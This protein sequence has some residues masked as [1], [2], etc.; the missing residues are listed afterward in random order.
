[1]AEAVDNANSSADIAVELSPLQSLAVTVGGNAVSCTTTGTATVTHTCS[2]TGLVA[3]GQT[4]VLVT[5][6]SED[7]VD[8]QM[9]I[10]LQRAAS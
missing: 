2:V 7:G 8:A 1:M 10:N 5:I 6:T 3:G 4:S 9:R